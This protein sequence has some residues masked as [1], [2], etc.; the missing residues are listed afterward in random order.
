MK[1]FLILIILIATVGGV[2]AEPAMQNVL[3]RK[4]M[5]L[6]GRWAFIT[7]VFDIGV[8]K[9]WFKPI[10]RVDLLKFE[11][12]NFEGGEK[13]TVPGDWNSQYPELFYLESPVWYQRKFEFEGS[14][15]E[16]QFIHFGAVCSD[17]IVYLNGEEIAR[18]VGG[19]TP[20]QVEVTDKIRVGDNELIVRVDNRRSKKSIPGVVFDWW[21]YGGITRDV[22]LVSTPKNYIEDYW[23]RLDKG[24]MTKVIAEVQLNGS[25]I[26]DKSVK[27]TIKGTKYSKK[28]KTD[29]AGRASVAFDAKLDL[30]SPENP[31]IYDVVVESDS[32]RVED[33]IGF[34]SIEVRGTDILLNGKP[35]FL[36][37]VNLHE[38]IAHEERRAVD[39]SDAEYL[40]D[41]ASELGCNFIRHTHYPPNEYLM[42]LCDERGFLMWEEIPTWG[43]DI[44]FGDTDIQNLA[45]TMMSEMIRRDKNRCGTIIWSVANET[46]PWQESRNKFLTTLIDK[47]RVWDNTRLISLASNA[48]KYVDNDYSKLVLVDE[49]QDKIDIIGVNKYMGW[50]IKWMATPTE[51]KW[52]TRDNKPMIFTEFGAGG[53]YGNFG[54]ENDASS[55]SEEYMARVYKENLASFDG[56]D[57]LRGTTPWVLFDF[58][59][60]RRPNAKFQKG[61]NRKGLLSPDGEKKQA[62]YIMKE[63][64]KND[65]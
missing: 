21:I 37:G 30:W 5:S 28:I 59:S 62:W 63:Y 17:A 44:D 16:R 55:F 22:D 46:A 8:S 33:R 60:A 48:V 57:N 58:R 49:L 25:D 13:L 43:V 10:D 7:D 29:S 54:D 12:V 61:W 23:V 38:E 1:R 45:T 52:V 53:V 11:E 47:C 3:G 15:Q 40:L 36:R 41:A 50:Y 64:Y 2:N 65:K 6:N 35:I 27:V 51:T 31:M 56:I 20:F 26:A 34:R 24:S 32:D 4:K 39:M 42:R 18:H 14:N 9:R 19:Y